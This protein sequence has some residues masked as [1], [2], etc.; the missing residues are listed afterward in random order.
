MSRRLRER[1]HLLPIMLSVTEL[2]Y[3]M[4]VHKRIVYS[5]I[6]AGLPLYKIGTKR[7]MLT[8]DVL[9]FIPRFFNVDGSVR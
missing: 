1:A 2:A 3:S 8:A 5:M 7:K 4:G 6:A 9:D